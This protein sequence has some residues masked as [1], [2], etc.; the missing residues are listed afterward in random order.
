VG[1]RWAQ[2]HHRRVIFALGI[3]D[4]E[5][6]ELMFMTAISI[7][8]PPCRKAPAGNDHAGAGAKRMLKRQ[9]LIRKLPAVETL[10]W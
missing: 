9:T 1:R 5:S 2:P 10:G 3:I 6:V 7:A 4:G 8:V